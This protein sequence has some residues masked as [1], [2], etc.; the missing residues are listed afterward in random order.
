MKRL[1]RSLLTYSL[2]ETVA[3]LSL[4][5]VGEKRPDVYLSV[6]ILI[7]FIHTSMDTSNQLRSKAKLLPIDIILLVAFSACVAYRLLEILNLM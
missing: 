2:F 5:S 1:D 4:I 6:T 3:L 7:H